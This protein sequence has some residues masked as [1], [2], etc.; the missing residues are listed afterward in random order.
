MALNTT[1]GPHY[2]DILIEKKNAMLR[3]LR[4][5]HVHNHHKLYKKCSHGELDTSWRRMDEGTFGFSSSDV[6]VT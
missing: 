3:H 6:I 5:Q 2:G 1:P 4:G